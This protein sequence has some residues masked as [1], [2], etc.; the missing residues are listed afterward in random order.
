MSEVEP[1]R[2]QPSHHRHGTGEALSPDS[3]SHYR[4]G[5][6][7]NF[8]SRTHFMNAAATTD[9][10]KSCIFTFQL[11]LSLR[12]VSGSEASPEPDQ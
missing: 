11:F 9:P 1:S 4:V 3:D 7:N 12:S 2:L 6:S 8:H 5:S 10:D